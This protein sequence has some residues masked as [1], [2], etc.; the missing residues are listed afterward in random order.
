[1]VFGGGLVYKGASR[2][3]PAFEGPDWQPRFYFPE[4]GESGVLHRGWG[5]DR[6]TAVADRASEGPVRGL[7][8]GASDQYRTPPRR[9]RV[10]AV[11]RSDQR[12]ASAR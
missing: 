5:A 3:I 10:L 6:T 1:M 12:A 2:R 9:A 11:T 4:E 7:I 8:T